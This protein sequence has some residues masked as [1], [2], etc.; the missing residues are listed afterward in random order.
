V[1]NRSPNPGRSKRSLS[2]SSGL[3]ITRCD[4]RVRDRGLVDE[5]YQGARRIRHR[6]LAD[7]LREHR[8][9]HATEYVFTQVQPPGMPDEAFARSVVAVV[10]ELTVLKAL[11][12]IDCPV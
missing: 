4:V 12:E 6:Q 9:E 3:S 5:A 8:L 11:L 10:H 2:A 7:A 1:S